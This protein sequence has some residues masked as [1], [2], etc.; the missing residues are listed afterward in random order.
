VIAWLQPSALWG[1]GLLALPVAI[2]LLRTRHADRVAFPSTRFVRPSRTAAVRLRSP[3]DLILLALRMGVV[4]LAVFSTAQ[5]LLLFPS[6][7]ADWNSRVAR[8]IV[9]DTSDSMRVPRPDNRT[10]AEEAEAAASAEDAAGMTFRVRHPDLAEAMRRAAAW[11]RSAPPARREIVV[12]SD[13]QH[14]SLTPGTVAAIDSD[15]GLR[16]IPVQGDQ[17]ERTV[18]GVPLLAATE[19]A[20]R[21]QQIR[22][23][24][25]GTQLSLVEAGSS[26]RTSELGEGHD[27]LR[28]LGIG[29]ERDERRLLATLAAAG[30]PAPDPAQ[31]IAVL[32][33]SAPAPPGVNHPSQRWMLETLSRIEQ[34]PEL[35]RL[36]R[37]LDAG[38]LGD[39][40]SWTA[41][42]KD[43]SGRPLVRAAALDRELMMQ[44]AAPISSYFAAAATRAVLMSRHGPVVR[45]ESEVLAIP[46]ETLA[47][48]SRPPGPVG[49]NAW[50]QS[51]DSDARWFWGGALVLLIVEQWFRKRSIVRKDQGRVA[52]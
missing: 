38:A 9:V 51:D 16:L 17:R 4:A 25:E 23:T 24:P 12:I 35:A 46:A 39:S 26:T 21:S 10:A 14:G 1:L 13:F 11:L 22:L 19:V 47:A 31:P 41:L 32:F 42:V 15:M 20:N 27:G 37:E 33:A 40:E 44:V 50:R 29:N 28:V 5:P 6:R 8:A 49:E 45:P 2:H 18:S 43:R 34:D 7:L 36:G 52:A 48:W 3:S 30:A